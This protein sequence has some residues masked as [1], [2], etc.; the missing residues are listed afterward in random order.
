MSVSGVD[1]RGDVQ[2]FE[3]ERVV[4]KRKVVST[5]L[6]DD[7]SV[8]KVI[9]STPEVTTSPDRFVKLSSEFAGRMCYEPGCAMAV[10]FVVCA[11]LA[12]YKFSDRVYLHHHESISRSQFKRGVVRLLEIGLLK[13][14]DNPHI[15]LV[16]RS[17]IEYGKNKSNVSRDSRV[18]SSR[19]E[20]T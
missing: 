1:I 5:V 20:E 3:V 4:L 13:E 10:L 18:G 16:N 12:S 8:K 9:V 15:Y 17:F 2:K 11:E 6:G 19:E 7:G 14:T